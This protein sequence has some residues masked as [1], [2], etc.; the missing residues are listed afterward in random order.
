MQQKVPTK[1]QLKKQGRQLSEKFRIFNG[2]MCALLAKVHNHRVSHEAVEKEWRRTRLYALT[3]M[4]EDKAVQR[5]MDRGYGL[6]VSVG[7]FVPSL[8]SS[9]KGTRYQILAVYSLREI[10]KT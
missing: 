4:K 1:T 3:L 8:R 5:M 7:L 6:A 10:M 2:M 9:L